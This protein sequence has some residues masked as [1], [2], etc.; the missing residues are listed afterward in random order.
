MR[1]IFQILEW[2]T[3]VTEQI[4][5]FN[6]EFSC[7]NEKSSLDWIDFSFFLVT[8]FN[9]SLKYSTIWCFMEMKTIETKSRVI[10]I[11]SK[12]NWNGSWAEAMRFKNDKVNEWASD[13]REELPILISNFILHFL[14]NLRLPMTSLTVFDRFWNTITNRKQW[15]CLVI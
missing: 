5:L 8:D 13:Q 11:L 2:K 7:S 12:W 3:G 6:N 9:L 1:G 10:S 15:V 14:E 4:T